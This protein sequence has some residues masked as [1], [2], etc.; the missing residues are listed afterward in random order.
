MSTH[1][2]AKES[3]G[4]WRYSWIFRYPYVGV[5]S[6]TRTLSLSHRW[7]ASGLLPTV[8]MS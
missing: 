2:F 6:Q 7:D 5:T 8:A 1:H 3:P 4:I